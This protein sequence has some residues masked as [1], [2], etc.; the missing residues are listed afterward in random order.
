VASRPLKLKFSVWPVP[1]LKLSQTR[2]VWGSVISMLLVGPVV[3]A[4]IDPAA[5]WNTPAFTEV[6]AAAGPAKRT[7]EA[8]A[9]RA[10]T[11]MVARRRPAGRRGRSLVMRGASCTSVTFLSS[12]RYTPVSG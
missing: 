9:V 12:P 4:P 6:W 7:V 1:K 11:P 8:I 10:A 2:M 3:T 5:T